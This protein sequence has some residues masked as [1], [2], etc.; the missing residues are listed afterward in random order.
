MKKVLSQTTKSLFDFVFDD[1]FY[2]LN[3]KV[4]RKLDSM[5]REI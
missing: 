4:L 2:E 3:P 5:N 1:I